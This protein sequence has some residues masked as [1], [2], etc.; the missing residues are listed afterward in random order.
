MAPLCIRFAVSNATYGDVQ[1]DGHGTLPNNNY[2]DIAV[3]GAN[4]ANYVR[5]FS[6]TVSLYKREECCLNSLLLC[7]QRACDPI[8]CLAGDLFSIGCSPQPLSRN[9]I[10]A[11]VDEYFQTD[12]NSQVPA[13][14]VTYNAAAAGVRT[15][16]VF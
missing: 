15:V 3:G 4:G 16:F 1:V 7:S 6:S 9:T 2:G 10:K 12:G 13:D 11:E 8:T 14:Q 5:Q